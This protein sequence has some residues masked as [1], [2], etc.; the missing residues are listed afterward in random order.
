M[1][2]PKP[3]VILAPSMGVRSKALRTESPLGL[4]QSMRPSGRVIA[5]ELQLA[6][7]EGERGEVD[8][9]GFGQ[10]ARLVQVALVDDLEFVAGLEIALEVDV[11]AEGVDDLAHDRDG[12]AL[13]LAGLEEAGLDRAGRTRRLDF[14]RHIRGLRREGA[15]Q[16]AGELDMLL[17]RGLQA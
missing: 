6:P 13:G 12:H 11:I 7:A 17:D 1:R 8:V 10:I 9:A 16:A 15:V 5:I 14:E 2:T 3:E 4:N